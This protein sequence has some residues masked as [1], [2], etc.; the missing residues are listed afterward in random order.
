MTKFFRQVQIVNICKR[1]N[2]R[3]SKIEVCF[4]K[5]KRIVGKGE[6]TGYQHFLLFPKCFEKASS[7]G[8]GK[9]WTVR[10]RVTQVEFTLIERQV[11]GTYINLSASW[12]LCQY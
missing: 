4:K 6:N 12:K 2:N 1:H 3:D 10:Y 9:P 11:L 5:A 7:S 8:S